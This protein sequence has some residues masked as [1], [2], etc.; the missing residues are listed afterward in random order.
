MYPNPT[1]GEV[2]FDLPVENDLQ[3]SM[4]ITN[5]TGQIAVERAGTKD[6]FRNVSLELASGTYILQ[7][8]STGAAYSQKLIITE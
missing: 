3:W 8:V 7:I 5:L 6:E 1:G 4:V 2:H